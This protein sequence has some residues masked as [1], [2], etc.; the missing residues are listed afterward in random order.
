MRQGRIQYIISMLI[1]GSVGLPVR[2]L[3]L[4]S[5]WIALIR[6]VAGCLFLL[7]I[8]RKLNGEAF[9]RNWIPLLVSGLAIGLNWGFVFEAYR[10]T[11]IAVATLFYYLAPVLVLLLSPLVLKER[12]T[13]LRGLTVAVALAGM[14]LVS[15]VLPH[16]QITGVRGMLMGFLAACLYATVMLANRF[17]KEIDVLDRTVYQ[18]G[19]AAVAVLPYALLREGFS[20]AWFSARAVLLLLVVGIVYTGV[21]Y[22]LFFD[23]LSR[24]PGATS[25]ILAYIDPVTALLLSAVV[26]GERMSLWQLAG[27]VLVLGALIIG[28]WA[29]RNK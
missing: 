22:L 23:G 21:A 13:L 26:L 10:H 2:W 5:G 8:R 17:L 25:A 19:F 24:L 11:T 16:G 4:P 12:L 20:L 1:F 15:G 6:G 27:A 7:A 14:A 29:E 3:P 18:L 9:R 28:Q